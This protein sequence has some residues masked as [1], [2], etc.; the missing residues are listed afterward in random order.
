[1]FGDDNDEHREDVM[2]RF[3]PA[4]HIIWHVVCFQ[5]TMEFAIGTTLVILAV[6]LYGS[7]PSSSS[8][9]HIDIEDPVINDENHASD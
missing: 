9:I 3:H 7:F 6:Y 8:K 5:V 4:E 1:M 2:L